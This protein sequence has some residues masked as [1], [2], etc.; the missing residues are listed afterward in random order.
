MPKN[1]VMPTINLKTANPTKGSAREGEK[2]RAISMG[3]KKSQK[4]PS[5]TNVGTRA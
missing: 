2:R 1:A 4:N 3:Q 5:R